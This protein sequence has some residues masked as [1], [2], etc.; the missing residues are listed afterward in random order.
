MGLSGRRGGLLALEKREISCPYQ[1]LDHDLSV[2]KPVASAQCV[3]PAKNGSL[4]SK[5]QSVIVAI[6]ML[7]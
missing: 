3:S 5:S 4:M 2:V 6:M 1:K 7:L